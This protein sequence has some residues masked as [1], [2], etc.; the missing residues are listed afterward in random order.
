MSREQAVMHLCFLL[1]WG[2]LCPE[3]QGYYKKKKTP[4]LG[5]RVMQNY[6]NF[7]SAVFL[8]QPSKWGMVGED[9]RFR[10]MLGVF[11]KM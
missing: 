2:L 5:N 1:T 6:L 4:H 10:A 8:G 7:L 11:V 9:K 3:A